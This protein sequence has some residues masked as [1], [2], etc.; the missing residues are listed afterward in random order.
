MDRPV[1]MSTYGKQDKENQNINTT[2][3]ALDTAV[4]KQTEIT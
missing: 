3:Y 4:S 2:Q 1:K